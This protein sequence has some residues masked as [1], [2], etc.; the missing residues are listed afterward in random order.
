M[1]KK[2]AARMEAVLG[3]TA[4]HFS[5]LPSGDPNGIPSYNR[6]FL[7]RF[8][9]RIRRGSAYDDGVAGGRVKPWCKTS[10]PISVG[11]PHGAFLE[12]RTPGDCR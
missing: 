9:V 12:A 1:T 11:H 2:V 10:A 3:I 8:P 6:D 5:V 4:G 7:D